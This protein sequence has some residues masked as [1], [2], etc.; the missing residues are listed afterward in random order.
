[1]PRENISQA[2][3]CLVIHNNDRRAELHTRTGG[4]ATPVHAFTVSDTAE[5]AKHK[6]CKGSA[7]DSRDVSPT[8]HDV[9]ET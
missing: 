2:V 3:G 4:R 1:M 6:R 9:N 5:L 7:F 8:R